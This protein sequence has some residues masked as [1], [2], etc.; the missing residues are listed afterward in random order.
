MQQ[1]L[2]PAQYLQEELTSFIEKVQKRQPFNLQSIAKIFLITINIYG[3]KAYNRLNVTIEE[4]IQFVKDKLTEKNSFDSAYSFHK[5]NKKSYY[6][7]LELKGCTIYGRICKKPPYDTNKDVR[8][9]ALICAISKEDNTNDSLHE[10]ALVFVYDKLTSTW[11]LQIF[12]GFK[13]NS[14]FTI[15]CG[16]HIAA[17][18]T[19]TI[20]I[21][22]AERNKLVPETLR[23]TFKGLQMCNENLCDDILNRPFLAYKLNEHLTKESFIQILTF[24][25]W[26][27]SKWYKKY[28]VNKY[29]LLSKK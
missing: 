19:F 25:V 10:R 17:D 20:D 16:I 21:P 23:I 14:S 2:N 3:Q 26:R 8:Y 11:Y 27:H 12:R 9:E 22:P 4:L 15:A 7:K 1:R 29:S 13:K 5:D 24:K 6:I 28:C 18:I